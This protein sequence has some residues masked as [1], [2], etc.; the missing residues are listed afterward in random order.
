[1]SHRICT[2]LHCLLGVIKKC[3]IYDLCIDWAGHLEQ[4]GQFCFE[5][6]KFFAILKS[7]LTWIFIYHDCFTL[8]TSQTSVLPE[9]GERAQCY[10]SA[11][12][13]HV[14]CFSVA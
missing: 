4:V 3:I 14:V 7:E 13:S 6:A 2:S 1:M 12:L 10:L 9:R 8:S 5:F 11:K